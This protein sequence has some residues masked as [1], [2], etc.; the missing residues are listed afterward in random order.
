MEL[1]SGQRLFSGPAA[2]SV[3]ATH[4]ERIFWELIAL[5]RPTLED[6]ISEIARERLVQQMDLARMMLQE[7]DALSREVRER[8]DIGQLDHATPDG[9]EVNR[10]IGQSHG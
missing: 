6:I 10:K 9:A 8:M 7:V 5:F 2:Q 3:D 4:L 1:D